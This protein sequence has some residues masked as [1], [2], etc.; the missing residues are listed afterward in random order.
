MNK[1]SND[2]GANARDISDADPHGYAALALTESLIHSLVDNSIIDLAEANN[3]VSIA[4]DATQAIAD[5]LPTTS[6]TIQQSIFLLTEIRHSL[7][8]GD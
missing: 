6:D 8:N 7:G 4:I 2:N 3:I 5:Y 1:S